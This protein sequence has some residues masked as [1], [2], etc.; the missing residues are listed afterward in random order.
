MFS[1]LLL[2]VAFLLQNTSF[3]LDMDCS[4]RTRQPEHQPCSVSKLVERARGDGLDRA[5]TVAAPGE[6][7]AQACD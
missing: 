5:V 4:L 7:Q 6:W 3:V 2:R 1:V